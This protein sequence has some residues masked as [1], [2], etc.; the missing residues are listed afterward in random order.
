MILGENEGKWRR[1]EGIFKVLAMEGLETE[2]EGRERYSRLNL[3]CEGDEWSLRS[4][5]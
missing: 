3:N 2:N 1:N 5:T 4:N